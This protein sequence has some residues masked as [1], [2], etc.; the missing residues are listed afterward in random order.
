MGQ[1]AGRGGGRGMSGL[2][3]PRM[4]NPVANEREQLNQQAAAGPRRARRR[5]G[6]I[7]RRVGGPGSY[8]RN[9][10]GG[11][12]PRQ[13]GDNLS[14]GDFG[15]TPIQYAPE[16]Y[17]GSMP[18]MGD[19][20]DS[21][22]NRVPRRQRGMSRRGGG[23]RDT[24]GYQLIDTPDYLR[25]AENRYGS[26]FGGTRSDESWLATGIGQG[27]L[28]LPGEAPTEEEWA[29]QNA[30][31]AGGYS[32]YGNQFAPANIDLVRGA[33]G[34]GDTQYDYPW[35]DPARD[36]ARDP[37]GYSDQFL[38][39]MLPPAMNLSNMYDYNMDGGVGMDDLAAAIQA[40]SAMAG[41]GGVPVN[42]FEAPPW[43]R[44]RTGSMMPAPGP[45]RQ[46]PN[47]GIYDQQEG[48]RREPRD[49][50]GPTPAGPTGRGGR[51]GRRGGRGLN[52]DPFL[53]REHPY[54]NAGADFTDFMP[55]PGIY[56]RQEGPSQE[57]LAH[58]LNRQ[59]ARRGAERR[60]APGVSPVG[61]TGR[62]GRGGRRGG[63]GIT[64]AYGR[65][66]I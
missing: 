45:Y 55:G 32:P 6:P 28:T 27:G 4:N 11:M 46:R 2:N 8:N 58:A 34:S 1:G 39:R 38:S 36:P 66:L 43:G 53:R 24:S 23:R 7:G 15:E 60:N 19:F 49:M 3:R 59:D 62:G 16:L 30:L 25:D 31:G 56:D 57:M 40:Q 26:P 65:N 61:P 13:G 22:R 14:L 48:P 35:R 63:G 21:P 52:P 9:V 29:M 47:T 44:P 10:A 51:G 41:Q 20:R 33:L 18:M 50:P 42:P 37:G 64:D 17:P 54:P 12:A 5:G